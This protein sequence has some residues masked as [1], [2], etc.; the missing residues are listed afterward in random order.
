MMKAAHKFAASREE[1]IGLA[2]SVWRGCDPD[3]LSPEE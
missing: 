2:I 1:F 3:D